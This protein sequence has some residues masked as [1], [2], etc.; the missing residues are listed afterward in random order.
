MQLRTPP[1]PEMLQRGSSW[2]CRTACLRWPADALRCRSFSVW[3]NWIRSYA[4]RGSLWV[5]SSR[6]ERYRGM[7]RLTPSEAP[8][9]TWCAYPR[10]AA[11]PTCLYIPI[12][13]NK[14]CFLCLER[15]FS[16]SFP[17]LA[18]MLLAIPFLAAGMWTR[19]SATPCRG[20]FMAFA[21]QRTLV[22]VLCKDNG[23]PHNFQGF[24]QFF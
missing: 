8:F 4:V 5:S 3:R 20:P 18:P 2:C 9:F 7:R 15:C 1:L 10:A 17:V 12:Q 14:A 13:L 22:S 16:C 24:W 23:F 19:I 21:S 11:V 6:I